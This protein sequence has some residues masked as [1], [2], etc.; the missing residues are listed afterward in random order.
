MDI[1]VKE[2]D[3]HMQRVLQNL[4]QNN[5]YARF[6]LPISRFK[7]DID[8]NYIR[9]CSKILYLMISTSQ[10][11]TFDAEKWSFCATAT[12]FVDLSVKE[13]GFRLICTQSSLRDGD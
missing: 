12:S 1:K 6:F 11:R 2:Q 4:H 10:S 3:I 7:H 5:D 8:A 9:F 13:L